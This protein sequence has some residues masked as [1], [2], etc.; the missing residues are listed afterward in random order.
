MPVGNSL[1]IFADQCQSARIRVG[2]QFTANCRPVRVDSDRHNFRWDTDRLGSTRLNCRS[3]RD[4]MPTDSGQTADI[5]RIDSDRHNF[6]WVF[7]SNMHIAEKPQW[8][9][10]FLNR[11]SITFRIQNYFKFQT[12]IEQD[13]KVEHWN[14]SI[15][16]DEILNKDECWQLLLTILLKLPK[17]KFELFPIKK[18]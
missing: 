9:M 11:K 14:F 2:R 6:R 18:T 16:N 12:I 15:Y 10:L 5:V 13:K 4:G 17:R 8:K 1:Q 7:K 3:G